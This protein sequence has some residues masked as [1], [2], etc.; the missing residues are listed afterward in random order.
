MCLFSTDVEL[1]Q[2]RDTEEDVA[3]IIEQIESNIV[4]AI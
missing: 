4:G 2:P 1:T 3:A